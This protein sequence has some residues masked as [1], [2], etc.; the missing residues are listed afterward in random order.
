MNSDSPKRAVYLQMCLY[1]FCTTTTCETA[2][3]LGNVNVVIMRSVAVAD[4]SC[5]LPVGDTEQQENKVGQ[6]DK[7]P[8]SLRT[9]SLSPQGRRRAGRC[10]NKRRDILRYSYPNVSL[11]SNRRASPAASE[12]RESKV[13]LRLEI[14]HAVL[15]NFFTQKFRPFGGIFPAASRCL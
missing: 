1:G 8:Q 2:N 9:C 11:L 4:A 6:V 3:M 12:L 14:S 10:R 7:K 13:S 5:E 15:L